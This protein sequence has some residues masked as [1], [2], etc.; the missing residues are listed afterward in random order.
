[1]KQALNLVN[2]IQPC[3]SGQVCQTI[4]YS[5][6]EQKYD[7]TSSPSEVLLILQDPEVQ[8]FMSFVSYD[9]QSLISEIGGIL[10]ITLGASALTMIN[11]FFTKLK[12]YYS[13]F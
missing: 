13:R 4:K 9:L 3:R 10:G 1:M 11:F 7:I 6:V 12:N 8:Y 5:F 2:K